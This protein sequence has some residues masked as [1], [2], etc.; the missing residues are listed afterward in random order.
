MSEQRHKSHEHEPQ[1]LLENEQQPRIEAHIHH[2]TNENEPPKE[3]VN[4]EE[5]RAKIEQHVEAAEDIAPEGTRPA[6]PE[7][8]HHPLMLNK[9]LKDTA[10]DRTMIRVQKKL[11]LP[12]R[13]LSKA[14][15]SPLLDKPAEVAGKTVARPS[16]MVG[17]ALFA[18]IGT[19]IMLWIA[20]NYGYQYNFLTAII[21][22]VL[23]MIIGLLCEAMWRLLR[24]K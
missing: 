11:S 6:A 24:S 18:L 2:E 20:Q 10:Y 12:N 9:H 7:R 22:F 13:Y 23:G 21:T 3:L 19:S 1:K 16:S 8:G 14:I 17:G 5:I 4:V 15:H